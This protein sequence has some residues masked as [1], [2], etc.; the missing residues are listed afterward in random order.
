ME[1]HRRIDSYHT[2]GSDGAPINS[3]ASM[4]HG[5]WYKEA[6]RLAGLFFAL[7]CV[8]LLPTTAHASGGSF[9]VEPFFTDIRIEGE[10]EYPFSLE[11]G[12]TTDEPIVFRL[13]FVDF[14]SLDESGGIAFLGERS[15]TEKR[16]GLTPWLSA[17]KD[18]VTVFP[19]GKET[20]RLSVMNRESLSPGG[21]YGAVLFHAEKE[22]GETGDTD[23]RVSI[24][25]DFSALVFVRKTGGEIRHLEYRDTVIRTD[26]LGVPD[27]VS[28]RFQNSGNVHLTPRGIAVVSDP[29]GR[30]VKRGVLNEE[31]GIIL[32]ESYRLYQ[33]AL[34]SIDMAFIPGFY[35]I[36]ATYRYDGEEH[37]TD[38]PS[39][40]VFSWNLAFLWA[41]F[42]L[43]VGFIFRWL[44]RWWKHR[45]N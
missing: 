1:T 24:R 31:S 34:K 22:G 21:H 27:T 15:D 40:R 42:L 7:A 25:S 35:T 6:Y 43:I 23:S 44:F 10:P 13:E 3:P 5:I 38:I 20:I 45:K 17:E 41:I 8:S 30:V 2:F 18:V 37:F 14:G 16:Y 11:V 36:N 32:P 12:N 19:G 33:V 39:Q 26:I 28:E 9:S 4:A 29:F